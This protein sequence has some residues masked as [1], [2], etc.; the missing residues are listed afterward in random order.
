MATASVDINGTLVA[1]D[2]AEYG[3]FM[4]VFKVSFGLIET[5]LVEAGVMPH[6]NGHR[7]RLLRSIA[8]LD[9]QLP[10]DWLERIYMGVRALLA[11]NTFLGRAKLRLLLCYVNGNMQYLIEAFDFPYQNKMQPLTIG[12]A[13]D[14]ALVANKHSFLKSNQRL[15]Y[16][17][18]AKQA[19]ANDWS[20]V[21]LCNE[22]GM[23]VE[24]TMANIF[25][26]KNNCLLTPPL[27]DGCVQ[28][29]FRQGLLS[30][31]ICF[32]NFQVQEQ[33]LSPNN[34][35]QADAVFLCNALR[36]M[37]RVDYLLF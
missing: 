18:G 12:L 30:G 7:A 5:I 28:G 2:S 1:Q 4:S 36:G 10:S 25:I 21:L 22:S 33:S 3:N 27:A 29:V 32:Q 19:A 34:I 37:R 31:S 20:D 13:K 14:V 11:G 8:F 24:S 15:V 17:I 16:E 9:W 35:Q 6:W 23:I 26:L